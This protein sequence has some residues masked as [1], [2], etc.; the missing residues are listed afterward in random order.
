MQKLKSKIAFLSK[1]V[2][3]EELN[4]LSKSIGVNQDGVRLLRTSNPFNIDS[5]EEPL[6]GIVNLGKVNNIR[7]INRFF[8]KVN[9]KLEIGQFYIGRFESI[10][11][12]YYRKKRKLN[13]FSL[14][15]YLF[16]SFFFFELAPKFGD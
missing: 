10:R 7:F 11:N 6:E 9:E 3:D 15:L 8:I 12:R 14:A 4:F 13:P 2:S 16:L 1:N 5:L